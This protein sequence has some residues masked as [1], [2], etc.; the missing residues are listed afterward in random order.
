MSLV[1]LENPGAQSESLDGSDRLLQLLAEIINLKHIYSNRI[2]VFFDH[3]YGQLSLAVNSKRTGPISIM[4]ERLSADLEQ[5]K[6]IIEI[7]REEI[8]PL[9]SAFLSV[10]PDALMRVRKGSASER[11]IAGKTVAKLKEA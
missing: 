2:E 6:E 11:E 8:L 4:I 1:P 9:I 7:R 5:E 3:G 10:S